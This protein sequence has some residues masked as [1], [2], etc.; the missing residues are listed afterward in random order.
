MSA[1]RWVRSCRGAVEVLGLS[2]TFAL[3]LGCPGSAEIP[4]S[5]ETVSIDKQVTITV[6]GKDHLVVEPAVF[7]AKLGGP[8]IEFKVKGLPERYSIEIDFTSQ[9][10]TKGPFVRSGG[11]RGRY[12]AVGTGKDVTVPSGKVDVERVKA[13]SYWKYEVVLRDPEKNDVVAIDPGGVFK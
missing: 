1:T 10:N 6:E 11:V 5:S 4:N 12:E 8:G 7:V 2:A 3:V 9:T 13:P